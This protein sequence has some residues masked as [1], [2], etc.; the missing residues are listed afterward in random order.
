M[1][2]FRPY[3]TGCSPTL[4]PGELQGMRTE[5]AGFEEVTKEM[6]AGSRHSER[7]GHEVRVLDG[8]E[9]RCNSTK[10]MAEGYPLPAWSSRVDLRPNK[11]DFERR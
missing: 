3:W 8:V 1:V 5:Q 6:R 7:E 11:A 9:Q 2:S 4:E 10:K